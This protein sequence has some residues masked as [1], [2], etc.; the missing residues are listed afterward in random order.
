MSDISIDYEAPPTLADFM[1][2][3][4][5]DAFVRCVIGPVGS[6]KSSACVMEIL[7]RAIEM[8][9]GADGKRRSRWV[10]IRNTYATLRDTTR[11]TFEQWIPD[12]ICK[13]YETEFTAELEFDDVH[14][15]V[16]FRALDRP[17]DVK[18]LLSLE[19]TGAYVNESKEVPK[20]IC[21]VLQTRIGRYPAKKDAVT[22][23]NPDGRFWSGIW[24]DTNPPDSDHWL[25][26]LFEET[27][28]EGFALWKQPDGLSA[29]AE[30]LENLPAGYYARLC[31]G[32][33]QDWVN[34]YVRGQYGF[35]KDGRPVYPEFN[36]AVHVGPVTLLEGE[37]LYLGMDFG[38]T[39]AA[40]LA[41]RDPRDGQWQFFDEL[42]S[43]SLGAVSFS[44][45]L[46]RII[47]TKY[48]GRPVRGWGDPAGA[49]RSQVDERTPF[50]VVQAAGLPVDPAPTNDFML[51]R[52]AVAGLLTRLTVLA[53]P[54]IVIDPACRVLR[55]GM[56]GAY[57]FKRIQVSGD[58]RYR[59][60][61]EKSSASHVAEAAQYLCVGEGEDDRAIHGTRGGHHR[62]AIHFK[63]HRAAGGAA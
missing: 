41:Q 28:P 42:V 50:D 15:E 58:E 43:D 22:P 7:R 35:V 21:E 46:A 12:A 29:S 17:V 61:P 62:G 34:V 37:T 63:V 2:G 1:F 45:E 19:I 23:E 52:E 53:R 48:A 20:A 14:A 8:P 47:K 18:K 36:D 16:M 10:I 49:Q 60:V 51:R 13:W 25:Y 31:S 27:K 55:K 11:K 26:R 24:M 38:L 33:D 39:P 3:E 57:V 5:S 54:A 9:R 6:G 40:V 59:D 32:K 44:R 56:A 30:N 4:G